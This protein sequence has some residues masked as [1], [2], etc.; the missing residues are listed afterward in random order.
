M[1][2]KPGNKRPWPEYLTRLLRPTYLHNILSQCFGFH[3]FT[4]RIWNLRME[5]SDPLNVLK[6]G[7]FMKLGINTYF[8]FIFKM[9]QYTK[10]LNR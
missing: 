9:L 7:N 5:K 6:L 8:R 10:A 2:D 3:S 4:I 1:D